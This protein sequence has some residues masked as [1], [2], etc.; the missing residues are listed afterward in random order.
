MHSRSKK[1]QGPTTS[2]GTA[3]EMKE[4]G[5]VP[6]FLGSSLTLGSSYGNE[7]H[8]HHHHD[9]QDESDGSCSLNDLCSA[10]SESG[11]PI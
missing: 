5:H 9:V 3:A 7:Q 8:H 10:A 4:L 1:K 6:S 2:I 11:L